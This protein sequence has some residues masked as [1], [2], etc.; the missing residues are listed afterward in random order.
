M[1][2]VIR[3]NGYVQRSLTSFIYSWI[4]FK[5]DV[6]FFLFLKSCS[7]TMK[8][9]SHLLFPISNGSSIQHLEFIQVESSLNEWT[10]PSSCI[11]PYLFRSICT[12]KLRA[13]RF[14]LEKLLLEKR[15][16]RVH[17]LLSA[18][19][20]LKEWKQRSLRSTIILFFLESVYEHEHD[21]DTL[22]TLSFG[23]QP[24]CLI[25]IPLQSIARSHLPMAVRSRKYSPHINNDARKYILCAEIFV[26]CAENL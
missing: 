16:R 19:V 11:S 14:K 8:R 18:M 15:R 9:P 21:V 23:L 26:Q 10:L 5:V 22:Y 4:Q 6:F 12:K 17:Q 20:N 1:F 3:L 25:S 24:S 2:E 7:L 13:W